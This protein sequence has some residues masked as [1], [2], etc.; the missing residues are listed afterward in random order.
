MTIPWGDIA[1]GYHTTLIPNIETYTGIKPG[2]HRLL[3][4]SISLKSPTP[5]YIRQEFCKKRKSIN[6]LRGLRH[7]QERMRAAWFGVK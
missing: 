1:T 2:V 3:K 5:I 7:L 6:D 4:T